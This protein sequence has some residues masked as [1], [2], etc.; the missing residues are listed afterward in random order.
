LS[1][2]QRPNVL[3]IVVHDVGTRL[4]CHGE[5]SVRTPALDDLAEEGVRFDRHFATACFC[6]PSRG[7][8]ITG[9]H[10][11]VNGLMGL[12][13][14]NWDLP[15]SNVTLAQM[16][17]AAGYETYL[18]GLQHEAT[19]ARRLGFQHVS[20]RSVPS[21]CHTVAGLVTEFLRS[22]PRKAPPFYARVGFSEVHRPWS[23]YEA[24]D[25]ADVRVPGYLADTPGARQDVA[26]FHGSIRSMDAAVGAILAALDE[27]GLRDDTIAVFTTDHGIAF[28][29]AKATLYDPGINTTLLMRWP[30]GFPG[31]GVHRELLSNVDLEPIL[32]PD[33]A[34]YYGHA[35]QLLSQHTSEQ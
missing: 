22:R 30:E 14:L 10:P 29:R 5:T 15:E 25:P 8:I 9:K 19:D 34:L 21:K 1:A 18:F 31:G 3:L 4:G 28:P 27:S 33:L 24:D 13:N 17:G 26:M 16:V 11:H 12:V 20:D 32:K 35:W 6:S 2:A 23:S 7:S